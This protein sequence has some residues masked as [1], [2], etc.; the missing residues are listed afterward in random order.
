MKISVE[1][2][3]YLESVCES[4]AEELFLLT[5]KNR[6]YLRK[7]LPW[8]DGTQTVE[9]TKNFIKFSRKQQRSKKGIQFT[10]KYKNNICGM[11][12]LVFI[13]NQN[14]KTEIGYWLSSKQTGKGIMTKSCKALIDYY[15]NNLNLNKI[16]I[17]CAPGNKPSIGI[18][19]RL[20]FIKEGLLRDDTVLNGK[21]ED[22][23]LFTLLRKEWEE[24][25]SEKIN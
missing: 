2:N 15:F 23:I 20:K 6:K 8:V 17:H 19:E 7:W 12:G 14:K 22:S 10:I 13:D 1:K 18:P 4:H 24:H 3:L 21:F 16:M 5:D 11:T 25:C 9:D